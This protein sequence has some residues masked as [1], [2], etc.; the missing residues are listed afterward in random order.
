[1]PK[2]KEI[3]RKEQLFGTGQSDFFKL[4]PDAPTRPVPPTDPGLVATHQEE[5]IDNMHNATNK[6]VSLLK[7]VRP[8]ADHETHEFYT[9]VGWTEEAKTEAMMG[10]WNTAMFRLKTVGVLDMLRPDL[11]LDQQH[12]ISGILK[13]YDRD[14]KMNAKKWKQF[15]RDAG[16][17]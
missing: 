7:L 6:T 17:I 11:T 1:M 14:H 13:D 4:V 16:V 2:R 10:H 8:S 15:A 3:S 12:E 9:S 5:R